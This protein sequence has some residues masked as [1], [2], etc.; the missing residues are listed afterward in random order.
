MSNNIHLYPS[1]IVRSYLLLE[2][3][4]QKKDLQRFWF[5]NSI[6]FLSI[7]ASASLVEEYNTIKNKENI[8]TDDEKKLSILQNHKSL[9]NVGLEHMSLGKWV[10]SLRE[11]LKAF[12][13][14][15]FKR[16]IMKSLSAL[17]KE[18]ERNINKL[19]TIRNADAHGEPI[20]EDKLD[21]E[22]S[23]RQALI[24]SIIT[25][26]SFF[27]NYELIL[28][29]KLEI[30]NGIPVY[31]SKIFIGNDVINKKIEFDTT[32][33]VGEVILY[34]KSTKEVLNLSPYLLYLGIA[35]SEKNFLG[36][37]S[38]YSNKEQTIGK[39]LNL[40]G[41]ANIDFTTFSK[42]N[43]TNLIKTRQSFTEIYSDP[44]SY[45]ANLQM[46]LKFD[47]KSIEIN[48]TN[49]FTLIF[50]NEKSITIENVEVII[51][52][53]SN[54]IINHSYDDVIIKD[55]KLKINLA[56]IENEIIE[57]DFN[58]IV[59]EQ[60]TFLINSGICNF[61]YFAS[62]SDKDIERYSKE[63]VELNGGEIECKD[64]NSRDKM[65][66]AI[67]INR[68]FIDSDG[69]EIS[70]TKIGD[71]FIFSI[72]VKNIGF[73]SA[74]N[75]TL[76]LLFPDNLDLQEGKETILLS[77][78]NPNETKTFQYILNS[79][80][81]NI[82]NIVMQ[83]II[84]FDLNNKKYITQCADDYYI[85]VRSD[86]KKE[87][88]YKIAS[89]LSDLYIDDEE[90]I[91]IDK[92]IENLKSIDKNAL[93]FYKKAETDAVIQNIRK[94]IIKKVKKAG[95]VLS[96]YIYDE[97]KRDSKN[98]T[99]QEVRKFLVFSV[100]NFAFFAINLTK[101]HNPTFHGL[102]SGISRMKK[103]KVEQHFAALN[104]SYTLDN[105][106]DYEF[107][108]YDKNYG[109]DFFSTWIS[110]LLSRIKT[111]YIP[112][113]NL[114]TSLDDYM[115]NAREK[116]TYV[117]GGFSWYKKRNEAFSYEGSVKNHFALINRNTNTLYSIF[118]N[119]STNMYKKMILEYANNNENVVFIMDKKQ[120]RDY[121]V[122][123]TLSY[124]FSTQ[125]N[126]KKVTTRVGITS[127]LGITSLDDMMEKTKKLW[128]K[129][130]H[131]HSYEILESEKMK[132]KK[133]LELFP[134]F[135]DA[136]YE[137][138]FSL[139][140][141]E[142]K[143]KSLIEIYSM[144]D[145]K[146]HGMKS[147]DSIATINISS[148]NIKFKLN[149]YDEN[150][151]NNIFEMKND[152]Y[153]NNIITCT[154]NTEDELKSV[155]KTILS[156]IDIYLPTKKI[157]IPN[158]LKKDFL[159]NMGQYETG[160]FIL[161]KCL[162]EQMNS[163]NNIAEIF[164]KS[165]GDLELQRLG[166]L[167]KKLLKENLEPIFYFTEDT[168][169]L[170]SQYLDAVNELAKEDESFDYLLTS[171]SAYKRTFSKK[172]AKD[173]KGLNTRAPH[174]MG[175]L[176]H[177]YKVANNFFEKYWRSI[178]INTKEEI[179]FEIIFKKV[180]SENA[181]IELDNLFGYLDTNEDGEIVKNYDTKKSF[182]KIEF[183]VKNRDE[184]ELQNLCKEFFEK[185]DKIVEDLI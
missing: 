155:F 117:S 31:L 66:P 71:E 28:P 180:K 4:D 1:L 183:F 174:P 6:S 12:N 56:K 129:L 5:E 169:E 178:K 143:P 136:L 14:L 107:I 154:T 40:D 121:Y 19:V 63:Q 61:E 18:Q 24:D 16:P 21:A 133:F 159:L 151:S 181:K 36:I 127:R 60:G 139:R 11:T 64:P 162:Y 165:I 130:C 82:Y 104:N 22:L 124:W 108:K 140:E 68:K 86:I 77:D 74:K 156:N 114:V 59:K 70:N 46:T 81:P 45:S 83:N 171:S 115:V 113:G 98:I 175:D 39:F 8:S 51:N 185:V 50:D 80:V 132:S 128:Q 153:K 27:E 41:S 142:K 25:S 137:K 119:T 10:G 62:D 164:N 168:I 149:F 90:Q 125:E 15:S 3:A 37:F 54:M 87:F 34:N 177:E 102:N 47:E 138:G 43:G 20:P 120:Q 158:N 44:E 172:I 57:K 95:W 55:S 73:S 126:Q 103:Y 9:T 99:E 152:I 96:E 53:P 105:R 146:P 32:P 176:Y 161:L 184:K 116:M 84:Y 179:I 141:N 67:N 76:D 30:E 173:Y 13:E 33:K 167:E 48:E 89:F 38:S 112:W 157:S 94:L 35:H 7:I 65:I 42:K 69:K 123:N 122:E 93:E 72:S 144:K 111:H 147:E 170:N 182:M 91:I 29:E 163:Y 100:N 2:D 150:I 135:I 78:L 75:V 79:K 26:M 106:I 97:T 101:G 85:V 131:I 49:N 17:Y 160:F 166:R 52:I 110:Q 148:Q 92:E 58:F 145:F 88:V 109:T 23:K 118:E 134:D